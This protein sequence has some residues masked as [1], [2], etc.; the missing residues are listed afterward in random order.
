MKI[1][2]NVNLEILKK[3][4]IGILLFIIFLYSG[5]FIYSYVFEQDK[6]AIDK[7]NF[8]QLEKIKS[9]LDNYKTEIEFRNLNEFNYKYK[10]D[11]KPIKNC[12]YMKTT[13]YVDNYKGKSDYILGF[14]LESLIY[15]FIY[16]GGNYVYP[17]YDLPID[18]ICIGGKKCN[19]D[20]NKASF[21]I[22]I[23]NSCD[24]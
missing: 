5:V 15:K 12:Y 14:Q 6:I 3:S 22:T 4:I 24:D 21:E 10:L 17:K 9:F 23:S 2:K 13:N 7:Y 1:L 18:Y 8:E 20:S 19:Y 11:I 16:F